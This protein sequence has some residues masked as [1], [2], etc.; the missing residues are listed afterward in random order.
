MVP[1]RNTEE[2]MRKTTVAW[3]AVSNIRVIRRG[4]EV[5]ADIKLGHGSPSQSIAANSEIFDES[6]HYLHERSNMIAPLP[7]YLEMSVGSLLA[8][9]K[10]SWYPG[11]QAQT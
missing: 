1:N 11:P 4:L 5:E 6:R 9:R 10:V 8:N 2:P 3:W 7:K